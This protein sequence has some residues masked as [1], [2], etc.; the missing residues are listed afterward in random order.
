MAVNIKYAVVLFVFPVMFWSC[1]KE[2]AKGIDEQLFEM[3]KESNGFARYKNTDAFL[4][5]SSGSAHNFPFLRTRFNSVAATML[6]ADK[7]VKSGAE[8]PEG[9]LIVK[10]LHEKNKELALYAI[11][12]KNSKSAHAD[13]RGWVWGYVNADGTVRDASSK[14]GSG[15]ISCHSQAGSID[16]TLMNKFFP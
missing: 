10:D 8:F 12:Y 2:K 5:K 14:K 4:E 13:S 1:K 7:K 11:L 6:D 16:Y 3:A 9:S 15:C